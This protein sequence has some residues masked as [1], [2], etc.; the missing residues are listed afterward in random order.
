MKSEKSRRQSTEGKKRTDSSKKE[1]PKRKSTSQSGESVWRIGS[2]TDKKSTRYR[3]ND[4]SDDSPKRSYG[5]K[6]TDGAT[7]NERSSSSTFKSKDA[8]K[9][10]RKYTKNEDE[11]PK[12]SYGRKNTDSATRNERSNTSTFKS[13]DAKYPT[14]KY[15]KTEDEAPKRGYGK[16]LSAFNEEKGYKP[17][18]KK[19][20]DNNYSDSQPRKISIRGK[21]SNKDEVRLN[22][23]IANSGICSRREADEFIEAG[24][25]TVNGEVVSAL[26]TKVKSTDDIRFNGQRL[27]GEKKV[28]ILLNKPK[29]YV[30]TVEDPHADKTVMDLIE[31]ACN[32][33]VYPVGRLDKNTTGVLLF[34]NDGELT[35]QL[36][37]PSNEK[38][39]VY[40]VF[41]DKNVTHN[42]LGK[43]VEGVTLEDGFIQADSANYVDN[44][45]SQVGVEIHSGRNRI[46]RRIFEHLGYKVV[47]LDRV[48]FAGLTKKGLKRGEWR[49]LNPKEVNMLKMGAYS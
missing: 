18:S 11:A 20:F 24:V 4:S 14:R 47:K 42:D 23:F 10:T 27:Q 3:T 26:G 41:L 17:K 21:K 39:K 44:E 28:Y 46:V 9:P 1:M 34:T 40:H 48:Y 32:E 36:T 45:K 12:R 5:R 6:N 19:S 25:V 22:K 31:G 15:T 16:K 2:S 29:G 43:L 8:K 7:K 49:M 35:K 33:R 38:M 13:K 30:T 37:H